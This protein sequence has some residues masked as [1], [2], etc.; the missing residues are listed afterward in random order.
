MTD[1]AIAWANFVCWVET[2]IVSTVLFGEYPF[3]EKSDE[4]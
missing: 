2:S 4:E 1:V 3:P